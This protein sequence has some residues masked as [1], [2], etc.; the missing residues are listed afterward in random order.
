MKKRNTMKHVKLFEAFINEAFQAPKSYITTKF[1][2]TVSDVVNYKFVDST[3]EIMKGKFP[4]FD[5]QIILQ[6]DDGEELGI[7][8]L[9]HGKIRE[10]DDA[11]WVKEFLEID[12]DDMAK[13]ADIFYAIA[14]LNNDRYID[15]KE[16]EEAIGDVKKYGLRKRKGVVD[17]NDHFLVYSK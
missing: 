3:L 17:L 9:E 10:V 6:D 12:S 13:T 15:T 4:D 11:E 5:F 8:T 1:S 16:I 2:A 14:S 7:Y